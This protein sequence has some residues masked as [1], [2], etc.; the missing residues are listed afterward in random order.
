MLV[1]AYFSATKIRWVFNQ[2]PEIA[3]RAKNNEIAFGTIDTWLLWNLTN[4]QSHITDHTNASRT[5]LYNIH[6]QNW[7]SQL[8]DYFDIPSAIL[9]DIAPS[10]NLF[11][12]TEPG[13]LCESSIGIYGMA[14]DQQAALFGQGCVNPG[15]VKNTYGTGCFML[16]NL[17]E[18]AVDSQNGL[19][20]TIACGHDGRPV[21]A[22][23]G[24]V[25]MAGAC[26]QWLRDEMQM[27]ERA[28]ETQTI[29]EQ[30]AD[31]EGVYVVPAFTGLGAPHWDM[32]ARAA[33]LGLT[34]GTGRKHVIRATLEAIAYQVT[35]VLRLMEQESDTNISV[36]KV[37]GG[38]CAND[39]LM[40][41]QAD[42][43]DMEI[44]RP[45]M[46]DSTALGAAL[47]AGIGCGLW[48]AGQWPESLSVVERRFRSKMEHPKREKFYSGWSKAVE[49]IKQ[50]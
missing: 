42:M 20:T 19:L 12:H 13:L 1:D 7:D 10:A 34:R 5:L 26:V 30:L 38:A 3:Q 4:G 47:L 16:M 22:L 40:Q 39:F 29:A 32:S 6:E 50:H 37:D 44:V 48:Q 27:I 15:E 23:E 49:T 43:L 24:S 2:F 14:G 45:K 25:F 18:Q 41:F 8:L 17:G 46:V 11:G 36:L 28:S 35:D 31:C 33:I 9:P 21:Y